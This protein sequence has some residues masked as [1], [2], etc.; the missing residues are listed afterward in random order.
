M[1]AARSYVMGGALLLG[2]GVVCGWLALRAT[3]EKTD[4]RPIRSIAAGSRS[5]STGEPAL[6]NAPGRRDAARSG[7]PEDWPQLEAFL[8]GGHDGELNA[9]DFE[10]MEACLKP[11]LGW[12]GSQC[13]CAIARMME[14]GLGGSRRSYVFGQMLGLLSAKD[15]V[16]AL[17]LYD[18]AREKAEFNKDGN[19][20][21]HELV[22]NVADQDPDQAAAWVESHRDQLNAEVTNVMLEKICGK[23]GK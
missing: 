10:E 23:A 18:E 17:A 5:D 2:V 1:S 20:S 11:A 9:G 22:M 7:L 14:D 8:A 13:K 15:S 6:S 4:A 19:Y 12:S 21:V 16:R 3:P